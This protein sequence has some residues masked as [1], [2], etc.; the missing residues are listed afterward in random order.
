MYA[1][2]P[3][4]YRSGQTDKLVGCMLARAF[5][6]REG[7]CA[8]GAWRRCKCCVLVPARILAHNVSV[9]LEELQ[10]SVLY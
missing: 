6:C 3:S 1:A 8:P 9:L 10:S 7:Q 2:A 4:L 5:S